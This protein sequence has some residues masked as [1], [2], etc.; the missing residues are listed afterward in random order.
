MCECA[1][2]CDMGVHIFKFPLHCSFKAKLKKKKHPQ[3]K[4]K[5]I[6][7]KCISSW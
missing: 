3:N 4:N 7:P 6:K 1:F 2:V 5:N